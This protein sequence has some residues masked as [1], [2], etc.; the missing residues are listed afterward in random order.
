[1]WV[2]GWMRRLKPAWQ[3]DFIRVYLPVMG[4]EPFK[5]VGGYRD[6]ET[7][8]RCMYTCLY[9]CVYV[10]ARSA[11]QKEG[12]IHEGGLESETH[13]RRER[14]YSIKAARAN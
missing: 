13:R 9:L 11:S 12:K 2:G 7:K 10:C 1:M 4:M 5:T 3:R 6:K 8:M 14:R